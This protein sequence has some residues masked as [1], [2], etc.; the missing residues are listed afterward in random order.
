[1]RGVRPRIGASGRSRAIRSAVE[2]LAGLA[3]IAPLDGGRP[4]PGAVTL[5]LEGSQLW[6][7]DL[8]EALDAGAERERLRK[9]RHEKQK[10]LDGLRKRLG[11]ESYRVK[12]PP[13]LVA[14]TEDQLAR[15]E[16]DLAAAE[17]A[18]AVLEGRP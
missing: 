6:L 13:H 7:S 1:M 3:R 12:A 16:A 15:A 4:P 10:E 17:R 9:L 8:V 18:L 2:T 11:N 14:Q 5:A